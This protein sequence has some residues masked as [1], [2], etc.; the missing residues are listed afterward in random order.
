MDAEHYLAFLADAYGFWYHLEYIP[1]G[2]YFNLSIKA[3]DRSWFWS[4]R[5]DD[6]SSTKERIGK[7]VHE[8]YK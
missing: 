2:K 6:D 3:D 7:I 5:S 4:F 8:F 1:I